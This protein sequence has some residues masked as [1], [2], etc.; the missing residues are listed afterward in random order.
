MEVVCEVRTGLIDL[1]VGR[2]V[3]IYADSRRPS[4]NHIRDGP[5]SFGTAQRA[6]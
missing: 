5:L 6:V 2:E 1:L 4:V 3:C